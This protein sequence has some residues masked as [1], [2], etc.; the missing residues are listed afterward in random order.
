MDRPLC[1]EK[2]E[3]GHTEQTRVLEQEN[4]SDVFREK[5]REGGPQ[6]FARERDKRPWYMQ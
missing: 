3:S 2:R 4:D 6:K 5:R 1:W